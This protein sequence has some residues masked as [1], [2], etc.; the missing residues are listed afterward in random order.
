MAAG[1]LIEDGVAPAA[2]GLQFAVVSPWPNSFRAG[3]AGARRIKAGHHH[4]LLEWLWGVGAWHPKACN[5]QPMAI[6]LGQ[7]GRQLA[8][9]GRRQQAVALQTVGFF[10]AAKKISDAMHCRLGGGQKRCPGGKVATGKV[11]SRSV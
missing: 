1:K 11:E 9:K 4:A 2:L 3:L 5:A 6:E 8:L 7:K 10:G